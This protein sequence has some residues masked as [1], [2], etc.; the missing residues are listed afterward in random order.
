MYPLDEQTIEIALTAAGNE[1]RHRFARPTKTQLAERDS[2]VKNEEIALDDNQIETIYDDDG[3]NVEL[4]NECAKEIQG[5][6]LGDGNLEWQ[7]VTD[8]VRSIMPSEH[9]LKAVAAMYFCTA[10]VEKASRNGHSTGFALMGA[11]EV[12]VRL[13]LGDKESAAYEIV[14]VLRRP[15]ESEWTAYRRGIHRIVQVR[16]AK[17]PRFITHSNLNTAVAFYDALLTRIEGATLSGASFDAS[18]RDAFV[19]AVDPIHKRVVARAF[20]DHWGADL[21]D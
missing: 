1:V 21:K 9:K 18:N 13:V 6:D 19:H 2:R 8:A 20:A 5:Y 16:G 7:A 11:T 12:K 3:A 14:H 4:W 15:T 17:H 10:E